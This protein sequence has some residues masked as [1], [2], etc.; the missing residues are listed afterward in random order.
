MINWFDLD[1]LLKLYFHFMSHTWFIIGNIRI[2]LSLE[3]ETDMLNMLCFMV[4]NFLE[5]V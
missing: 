4:I 5:A 2:I 1:N 3:I